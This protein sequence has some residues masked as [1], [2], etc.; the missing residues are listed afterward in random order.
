[1][2][3]LFDSNIFIRLAEK[4][5]PDRRMIIDAIRLL[6]NADEQI[7]Y[8]P[9]VIAEFWNVCT[10]PA[11]ARGGL[12]LSIEQTKRKTDIIEKYFTIL[13][14]GAATF[15]EWRRLVSDLAIRGVQV[16]DAKLAASMIAY[17]IPHLVMLNIGDFRR[18]P[19]IEAI[20]PTDIWSI[21]RRT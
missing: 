20:N 7:Y 13:Q 14:D 6:R 2:A 18:F 12:G 8:T 5:S 1:M 19:K 17:N 16:H 15:N 4:N 3:F 10:R 11:N 9:Q 21:V